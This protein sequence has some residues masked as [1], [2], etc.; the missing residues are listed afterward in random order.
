MKYAYIKI[1]FTAYKIYYKCIKDLKYRNKKTLYEFKKKTRV[2][3]FH[4]RGKI[5]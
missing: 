5:S 1:R 4:Q 2:D 3:F